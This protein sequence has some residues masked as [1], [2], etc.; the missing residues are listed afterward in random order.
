MPEVSQIVSYFNQI[1]PACEICSRLSCGS[2]LK[3]LK[4]ICEISY[5]AVSNH[6]GRPLSLPVGHGGHC[7][8]TVIGTAIPISCVQLIPLS[9]TPRHIPI[10]TFAVAMPRQLP[11]SNFAVSIASIAR[12]HT[13][14]RILLIRVRCFIGFAATLSNC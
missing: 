11:L 2:Q 7:P 10:V 14:M 1:Q 12:A 6:G 3:R 13:A 8:R 9:L 4:Y 5:L